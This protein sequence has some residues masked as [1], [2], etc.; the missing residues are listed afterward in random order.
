MYSPIIK[1]LRVEQDGM[2]EPPLAAA[3][4]YPSAPL[5]S[6]GHSIDIDEMDDSG[7]SRGQSKKMAEQ[8]LLEAR[9]QAE[10][11]E[12]TAYREGFAQGERAG[13][14]FGQQKIEPIAKAIDSVVQDLLRVRDNMIKKVEGEL[15][16]VA[17]AIAT[18]I[19]H[20]ELSLRPEDVLDV[21]REAL[22]RTVRGVKMTM[23]INP[24]D[25]EYFQQA[26]KILPEL[27][28][29]SEQM[30]LAPD[31]EVT[32]G[33]VI[34]ETESGEIDATLESQLTLLW[35]ALNPEAKRKEPEDETADGQ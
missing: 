17:F 32:R 12:Q 31:Y 3:G 14:E 1:R 15:I 29:H 6:A 23:R 16:H 27:A 20:K 21:A 5:E 22:K 19:L 10:V 25:M 4:S 9:R 8:I 13:M 2:F 26:G 11:I 33:G 24:V 30:V 34:V 18:R 28:K 7:R 35:E